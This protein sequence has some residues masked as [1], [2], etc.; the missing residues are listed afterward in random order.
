MLFNFKKS[1]FLISAMTVLIT[2]FTACRDSEIVEEE[3]EYVEGSGVGE[4]LTA[5]VAED[6][7]FT[8]NCDSDNTFNPY[9]DTSSVNQIFMPLVYEFMFDVDTTFTATPN[10]IKSYTTE[11]GISWSFTVDTTVK[12]HDGSYLTAD[13]VAYSLARARSSTKYSGRLAGV[14]GVSAVSE[15]LV[16]VT[17]AQPNMFFPTLLS[18]PVIK[19]GTLG[20]TAP[21]GSGAYTFSS[22]QTKLEL[23]AEHESASLMPISTIYLSEFAEPED[24]IA[25]FESARLDLVT[26]EFGLNDYGYG[27]ISET[28]YANTTNMHYLGFNQNSAFFAY[29]RF[30]YFVTYAI[31]RET[32]VTEILGGSATATTIPINPKSTLYNEEFAGTLNYSFE[33]ATTALKNA[34]AENLDSDIQLEFKMGSDTV[35]INIDFIVCG[36]TSTKVTAAEVI[37]DE[38]RSL[39]LEVNLQVL[40]WAD[41]NLAL[42]EGDFDLYYAEVKLSPDFNIRPLVSSEGSLNV[43]GINIS[44]DDEF[45]NDFYSANEAERQMMCDLMLR[46]VSDSAPF[47]PIC[48]EKSIIQTHRGVVSNISPTQDNLFNDFENWTIELQ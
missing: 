48:F 6:N 8:L 21:A 20:D 14:Y 7:I 12:F 43:G 23:W 45:M 9:T 1:L 34:G 3:E 29:P 46:I 31:N 26:S 4:E 28:R 18:I 13:D 16:M 15:D 32:I 25:G 33:N 10:L 47:V 37:A 39:G 11:D 2:G 42:Q 22:D 24:I 44:N 35:D 40:S 17:L 36:D 19:D 5:V 41:Y 27:S 38:L 30:R